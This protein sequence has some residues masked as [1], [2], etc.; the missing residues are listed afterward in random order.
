MLIQYYKGNMKDSK[1]I[2]VPITVGVKLYV[3]KC[4]KRQEEEEDMSRLPYMSVFG[5]L[6]Y[7]MDYTRK[8]IA[9]A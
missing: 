7:V 1:L 3:K 2:K 5:S 4:L 6:K 8:K 9:H